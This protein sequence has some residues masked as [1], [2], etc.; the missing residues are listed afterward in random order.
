M[1]VQ[2]D[3]ALLAKLEKLSHL[4]VD[5]EKKDEIISQLSEILEYVENL[6]ELDTSDFDS[7]FSTLE[8]GTPM[9]EDIPVQQSEVAQKI[10]K[11]APDSRDDFFIVPAIIN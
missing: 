2:I 7:Y 5:E 9:K 8:G 1:I 6:K 4:R 10:L 3:M 11:Y